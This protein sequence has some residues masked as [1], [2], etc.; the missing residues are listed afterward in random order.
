MWDNRCKVAVSGVGFSKVTRSAEIPLAAHALEAVK[1]AVADSGLEMSD[2]DGLSTYPELPATGHAEVDGVSIVSVNCM[3]AMLKLPDLA[4]HMQV[5]SVNIGGAV[6]QAVNALLAG[7]CKYVVVWRAMHNPQGTYQNL[8]GAHA[9]GAAQ[10]TGPYGFGGPGQGMAVAYT[11]WLETHNQDREKM[12]TLAVTQRRHTQNNPHAYFYG[13]PLTREDYLSSR[14]VAYP[15]CL[16]DCDIPVQGAAAIVLTTADRAKDLKPTPA[17]VA[18]YGQRLHFEVAGRIGSLSSYMEGGSSSSKLT[19]ERSGFTP[20]D[21]D[22]AQIYDGFSASVIYGLES[23]GFCKEGEAL[24]F[25]QDGRMELDGEL[26][27][28][29]FGGSLGTGRIHGLWH[30]IEGALQ[31][32]GRAGPRQVKDA[33]VSFVGASAPIVTGTTFIFVGDPY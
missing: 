31:A 16:F 14:M 30:I 1:A 25:I 27:M 12:A 18:G 15:F 11:R 2:I 7:V 10:F 22:V 8:P 21:V 3:M 23:Y 20:K 28:N 17:Y 32:S 13:T 29:T 19:W 26:P 4:W 9:H 24:D 6:Q 5:G 33:N